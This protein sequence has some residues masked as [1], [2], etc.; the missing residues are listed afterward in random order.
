MKEFNRREL[1]RA[2]P[3]FL[4]AQTPIAAAARPIPPLKPTRLGQVV[5]WREKKYTCVRIAKKLTWDKG[6]A[7]ALTPKPSPTPSATTTVYT[8]PPEEFLICESSELKLN[9]P[10]SFVNPS[11][12]EPSRGYIVIRHENGIDAFSNRCTHEGAEV[13]IDGGKLV[14]YRHSSY[15]DG[16]NGK[17]LSGPA[18]R[19]L[20]SYPTVERGGQVFVIDQP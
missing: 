12:S 4:L 11:L 18:T 9:R 16:N 2:I 20:R 8:P 15:F 1:L 17:V 7:L 5:I 6:V 14:C 13:E 3:I 10:I 19:E